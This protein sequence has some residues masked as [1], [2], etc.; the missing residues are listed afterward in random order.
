MPG[1]IFDATAVI[2]AES[3]PL[4]KN[5]P[6]GTSLSIC[7]AILFSTAF[8]SRFSFS[9]NEMLLS[10]LKDMSIYGFGFTFSPCFKNT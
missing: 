1:Q 10:G 5:E 4:D 6:T 7:A 3:I 2:T 9:S 8:L